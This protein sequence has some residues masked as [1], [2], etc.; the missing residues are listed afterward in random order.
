LFFCK[1][2]FSGNIIESLDQLQQQLKLE[3]AVE[4][5]LASENDNIE[6]DLLLL[7]TEVSLVFCLSSDAFIRKLLI[8]SISR[9]H[10]T[11]LILCNGLKKNFERN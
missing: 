6:N 2:N 8:L 1:N 4:K 9:R 10:M 11:P 5:Q 7:S 3:E